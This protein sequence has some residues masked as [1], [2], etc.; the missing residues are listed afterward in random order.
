MEEILLKTRVQSLL[1]V[2]GGDLSDKELAKLLSASRAEVNFVCEEL[3]N[4]MNILQSGIHLIKNLGVDAVSYQMVSNPSCAEAVELITKKQYT[5]ELSR[6]ALETLSIIA[7][8]GPV[9][10]VRLEKIRGVNCSLILRNLKIR[11]LVIAEYDVMLGYD[12]YSVTIDFIKF[13]GLSSLSELPNYDMIRSDE[14]V[15]L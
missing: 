12:R 2:A 15:K 5:E 14:N 7:Y 6:P 8:L 9:D 11:G 13:L 3:K 10:K 1:F 4:E